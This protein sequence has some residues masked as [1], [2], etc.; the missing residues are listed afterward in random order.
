M[1]LRLISIETRKTFGHPFFGPGFGALALL[2]GLIVFFNQ[3]QMAAGYQTQ[4]G[5][6]RDFLNSLHWVNLLAYA[7]VG[8]VIAAWDYPERGIQVWLARGVPRFPLLSARLVVI[9]STGLLVALFAVLV[10]A[11]T[12]VL[13]VRIFFNELSVPALPA[14]D[15]A[16]MSLRLFWASLPYLALTALIGVVTRSPLYA[17]GGAILYSYVFETTLASLRGR[18]E[19]L[20]FLPGQLAP[21][22]LNGP[23]AGGG[24]GLTEPQ[25]IAATGLIALALGGLALLWFSRQDLG[26]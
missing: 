26:G 20:Q 14:G 7:A 22:L 9:V 23:A 16:V 4:T 12:A 5:G 13:S 8:A 18:Y 25:A 17:A 24:G 6:Y 3:A 11:L 10:S 2:L 21:L 1:L 15:L 19:I